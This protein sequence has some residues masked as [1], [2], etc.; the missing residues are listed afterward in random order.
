MAD[1][2]ANGWERV[3]FRYKGWKMKVQIEDGSGHHQTQVRYQTL[4]QVRQTE[5]SELRLYFNEVQFLAVPLFEGEETQ[6]RVT[7]GGGQLVSVDRSRDL[8]YRIDFYQ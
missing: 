7:P 4:E 8:T 2:T 5:P 1:T 3:L 6:H